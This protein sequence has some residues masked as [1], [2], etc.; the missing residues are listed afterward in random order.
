VAAVTADVA[1]RKRSPIITHLHWLA[2]NPELAMPLL[3]GIFLVAAYVIHVREGSLWLRTI[4]LV[5]SFLLCSRYTGVEMLHT[6][7]QFR[8]NIDVLMFVAAAGAL[9]WGN[10]KKALLLFLFGIGTAGEIWPWT[11]PGVRSRLLPTSPRTPRFCVKEG[12]RVVPPTPGK[13]PGGHP[14]LRPDARGRN[15][16]LGNV[17]RRPIA[18]HR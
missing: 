18:D 8:S 11:A 2:G 16:G 7:R 3:G 4:M 10:P 17:L 14:T 1:G 15:R 12:E 5:A 13:R 9:R 6:L